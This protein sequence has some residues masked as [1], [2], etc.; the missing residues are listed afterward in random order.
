MLLHSDSEIL[1]IISLG[2][3]THTK[4]IENKWR[5]AM[6]RNN[7]LTFVIKCSGSTNEYKY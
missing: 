3:I 5:I 2:F 6:K 1:T 7:S 4:L